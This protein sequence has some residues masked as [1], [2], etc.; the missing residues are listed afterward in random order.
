VF[1]LLEKI[2]KNENQSPTN[3]A[4]AVV[5]FQHAGL[6]GSGQNGRISARLFRIRSYSAKSGQ[7]DWNLA[8]SVAESVQFIPDFNHFG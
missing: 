6:A 1:G 3:A 5:R 8:G 4:V 7:N 2:T